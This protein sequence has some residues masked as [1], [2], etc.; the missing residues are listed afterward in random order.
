MAIQYTD[1]HITV[2][3][4]SLHQTTSTV[5]HTD[6]VI[7]IV[8]PAWL[9]E[10]VEA[11]QS[12]VKEVDKGQKKYLFFTH[13]DFDHILAYHAFPE[14]VTI[15][16]RGFVSRSKEHRE[17]T[18][19]EIQEFDDYYYIERPYVIEYPKIEIIIDFDGQTIHVGETSFS[20][21]LA[22]GHTADGAFVTVNELGALIVGDYLSDIEF[23]FI[24]YHSEAY[25]KTLNKF[26]SVIEEKEIHLLV[27]GHGTVTTERKEMTDRI[28]DSRWYIETLRNDLNDV[29]SDEYSVL[30]A[31]VDSFQFPTFLMKMHEKNVEQI[32]KEANE[33]P[34]Q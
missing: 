6:D 16:S 31:F 1:Q 29:L 4:S 19:K 17:E 8:D 14:A 24:Y 2:F 34:H 30:E 21:Y 5:V 12:F 3:Q 33:R 18:V 22:P 32:Q 23:P 27:P 15:A 9:P 7:F 28:D 26:E 10:E 25:E 13:S 11:I 20:F